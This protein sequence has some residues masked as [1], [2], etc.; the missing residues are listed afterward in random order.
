MA[1]PQFQELVEAPARARVRQPLLLR[2]RHL[3]ESLLMFASV[4]LLGVICLSWTVVALPLLLVL[5]AGPARRCGRFGILCG[6]RLYVWTL[7]LMGIYRFDLTALR[8]LRDGP[9][10]VL[11][12]NHPSLIDALLII[13]HEPRVACVM[14]SSLM[15]NVFLGA[16][17]RLARYI[18]SEPPRQMIREGIAE[19]GRG[20]IV[21]LFPEGTRT[22]Q[23]PINALQAGVGII[24]QQADVPVQTLIIE[25]DSPLLSKGWSLFRRAPLPVHYRMRLGHRF[26]PPG[27]ARAFVPQ[28]DEYLRAELAEAHAQNHWIEARRRRVASVSERR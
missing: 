14:K 16:G 26:D 11:A 20:G 19:L 5:P 12:P 4:T 23:A 27:D 2:L 17:A 10:V 6:F 1:R 8:A 28:L 22:T 15:N 3:I 9:P 13:A 21:L 7:G 18:R 24:A 25:I